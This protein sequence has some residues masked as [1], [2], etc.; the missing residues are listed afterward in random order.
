MYIES[1]IEATNSGFGRALMAVKLSGLMI[2][3]LI[4][5]II[6]EFSVKAIIIY[7]NFSGIN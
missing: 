3:V 5:A 6:E 4:E 1:V 7:F 2:E